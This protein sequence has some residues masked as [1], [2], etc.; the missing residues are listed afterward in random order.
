VPVEYQ[1][2]AILLEDGHQE[3]LNV[4]RAAVVARAV[5]GMVKE[6]ELPCLVGL[7][8]V[9]QPVILGAARSVALAGVQR[10]EVSVPPVERIV[11][12]EMEDVG[13]TL[14]TTATAVQFVIPDAGIEGRTVDALTIQVEVRP[15]VL[16]PR[17]VVTGA[18][19]TTMDDV[20]GMQGQVEAVLSNLGCHVP[21]RLAGRGAAVI[22][23]AVT[24]DDEA[25]LMG[26]RR[27]GEGDLRPGSQVV[28]GGVY[29]VIVGGVRRQTGDRGRVPV[30]AVV[31][32]CRG[33]YHVAF[34]VADFAGPRAVGGPGDGHRVGG[35]LAQI[36][37]DQQAKCGAG[38]RV[39]G[40]WGADRRWCMS[41][42]V[43][44]C[45]G[46]G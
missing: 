40:A 38:R 19:T 43:S 17:A 20:A 33:G 23:P 28:T 18:Y 1:I 6:N 30:F 36:R 9:H 7:Q 46:V 4:T 27:A 5:S 44:S 26:L 3:G 16:V 45:R 12:R 37:V 13:V 2:H 32:V 31:D 14:I 8:I 22:G 42:S 21:S 11:R 35:G 39:C 10:H 25:E 15:D 34:A 29:P 41:W 24:Q